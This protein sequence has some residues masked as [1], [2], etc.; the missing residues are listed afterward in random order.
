MRK[1]YTCSNSKKE[2]KNILTWISEKLWLI[3]EVVSAKKKSQKKFSP[4]SSIRAII[5]HI[6]I[7]IITGEREVPNSNLISL[8]V[9]I[10]LF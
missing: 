9:K 7:V 6:I 2:E 4:Q 10:N 3:N 8:I 1:Y 5:K